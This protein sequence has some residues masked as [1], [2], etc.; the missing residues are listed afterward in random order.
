MSILDGPLAELRTLPCYNE[1]MKKPRPFLV[2][3]EGD[4]VIE[5]LPAEKE[6]RKIKFSDEILVT[7][8]EDRFFHYP[9]ELEEVEEEAYEIE[10]VEDDGD[11]DFY[12]EIVDGE[13]FYVFETEDD[14]SVDSIDELFS[15][16]EAS[17]AS[18]FDSM[19]SGTSD[20]SGAYD[21]ADLVAP[22]LDGDTDGAFMEDSEAFIQEIPFPDEIKLPKQ[23]SV[24]DD[25]SINSEQL[26]IEGEDSMQSL[27][28]EFEIPEA[29]KK[30]MDRHS[31][32]KE[33]RRKKRETRPSP[34]PSEASVSSSSSS[35]SS[36]S[37]VSSSTKSM[38]L[39][40]APTGK[41]GRTQDTS[42]KGAL[43]KKDAPKVSTRS[44]PPS[45]PSTPPVSPDRSGSPTGRSRSILKANAPSPRADTKKACSKKEVSKK[46]KHAFTKTYVRAEQF[47][48]EHRVYSWQKPAWTQG[49]Q[50]AQ[51]PK[52]E[53][54]RQ[55][56]D[57]AGVGRA[58]EETPG[59]PVSP[60]KGI[61]VDKEEILRRFVSGEIGSGLISNAHGRQRKLKLSVN[62]A[63]LR[64][65]GD[66]VKPITKATV[67]RTPNDINH[68]ANPGVLRPTPQVSKKPIR[69]EKPD[70]T[71]PK[72]KSTSAGAAIKEGADLQTPITQRLIA[73]AQAATEENRKLRQPE[74]LNSSSHSKKVQGNGL[75]KFSNHSSEH[76]KES[77][78]NLNNGTVKDCNGPDAERR[79]RQEL[80]A[81]VA[82]S[83]G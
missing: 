78:G 65:G 56:G 46:K 18:S 62:G 63:K 23:S 27:T 13:V 79:R 24:D 36:S 29:A 74:A 70:W 20:L 4:Q 19:H 58:S 21:L 73:D 66:I 48:G 75:R 59:S 80:L 5:I 31:A 37:C 47:D 22:N 16:D 71:L 44:P 2:P 60:G 11:A 76:S 81:R 12:L 14:L 32:K 15:G 83:W 7:E 54:V 1:P 40:P 9:E 28:K 10:I 77:S 61:E 64:E 55:G 82:K 25:T 69:W 6:N 41:S 38:Q 72:L 52:G 30:D 26:D 8:I 53:E 42:K 34:E 68:L 17:V 3:A 50:L 67:F 39:P 35:S 49:D 45:P 57:L 43:E 33:G 51:T